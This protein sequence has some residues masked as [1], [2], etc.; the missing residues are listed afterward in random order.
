MV[1]DRR[2]CTAIITIYRSFRVLEFWRHRLCLNRSVQ[3]SE[4][5]L[6]IDNASAANRTFVRTFHVFTIAFMMNTVTAPHEYY[7]LR[8]R[9]HVLATYR[10]VAISRTFDTAVSVSYRYRHAHKTCL[11]YSSVRRR[12]LYTSGLTLQWKKSFPRPWPIRQIPQSLQWYILFSG[13]SSQ[14]L[15]TL[16]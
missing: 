6:H 8:R 13:S 14:S 16:Q 9:E 12:L 3:V 5:P 11:V 4:L 2:F 15:H 10:A 1:F 7:S